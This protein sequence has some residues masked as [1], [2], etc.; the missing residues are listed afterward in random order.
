MIG[1]YNLLGQ[2]DRLQSLPNKLAR[3][4]TLSYLDKIFIRLCAV[5][6][7]K[8]WQQIW[9]DWHWFASWIICCIPGESVGPIHQDCKL[10]TSCRGCRLTKIKIWLF[11]F[12]HL[13]KLDQFL[14]YESQNV[15]LLCVLQS[16]DQL[17][18][19]IKKHAIDI[20]QIFI[21]F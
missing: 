10:W 3:S 18:M 7:H 16:V 8:I 6:D 1:I 2:V 11:N 17:E 19:K 21:Y 5:Y 15:Y 20:L 13:K 4:E 14:V 9:F 12:W